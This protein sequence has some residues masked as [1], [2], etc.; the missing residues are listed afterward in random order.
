MGGAS[1]FIDHADAM[2]ST[3]M[4]TDPAGGVQ[5][6]IAYYP[7]GQ[8]LAQGGIRQSVVWAGL[9]WQINDPSI[10][11]ATREY[12]AGLGRWMTPDPGGV[13]V[14]KLDDPQTWNMYA[15]VTNNPTS[16]NDPSGEA[17][18]MGVTIFGSHFGGTCA[19]DLPPRAAPPPEVNQQAWDQSLV[20]FHPAGGHETVAH[21]AGVVN[22]ETQGMRD[23][24]GE[25]EPL[26][27]ARE[28]IAH[29]RIN[30]IKE[31]GEKVQIE[32]RMALPVMRGQDYSSSLQAA[33]NAAIQ[34]MEGIDPTNGATHY[35][36]RTDSQSSRGGP[37]YGA[38]PQTQSGPY[39]SPTPYDWIWTYGP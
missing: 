22:A 24:K 34:D 30:G 39:L 1:A 20:F 16:S 17:C 26:L 19:G 7:W 25:N 27:K 3:T 32:R 2:G 28:K 4:E 15:Y 21:I 29:V 6:K 35:N 36:M 11:S 14:V 8:V 38:Q 23:K 9:D 10:P 13:K 18:F 33:K 31:F 12:S 37:F 5:W